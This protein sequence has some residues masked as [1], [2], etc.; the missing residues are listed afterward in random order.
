MEERAA[1]ALLKARFEA[2]GYRI[3]ENV[4]FDGAG[5]QFEID[6]YDAARQVGYEYV[7]E[8]AGDSWDVGDEVVDAL[9]SSTAYRVLIVTEAEAPDAVSLE[10]KATA[11]L[12]SLPPVRVMDDTLDEEL[13]DEADDEKP[14]AKPAAKKPAAKKPAAKKPAAKKPAAKKPVAKKRK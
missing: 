10:T 2:A 14:A 13:E 11:F 8:E 9:A 12:A 5:V 7:S 3:A 4:S 1:C 6:G